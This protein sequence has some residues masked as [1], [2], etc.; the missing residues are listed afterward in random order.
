MKASQLLISCT[1]LAFVA[2]AGQTVSLHAGPSFA[3][4]HGGITVA[5]GGGA[6]PPASS[7][8]SDLDLGDA[9]VSP[10]LQAQI[11]ADGHRFRI[12]GLLVDTDGEG[13]LAD[14]FGDVPAGSQ[15]QTSLDFFALV[16]N[17]S[18]EVLRE[19][20]YRVGIGAQLG[21]YS[22][23]VSATAPGSRESLDTQ[24]LL[25]MPYLEAEAFYGDLTL[26]LSGGAMAGKFGDSDGRYLDLEAYAR[27]LLDDRF[28]VRGGY[29]Y[30]VLDGDGRATDRDFD[31]DLDVRGFYVTAGVR[32]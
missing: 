3:S 23:D 24:G 12:S 27:W 4:V 30:L 22:L 7:V 20:H 14:D 2:C 11:D 26:G 1:S 16:G 8:D 31:A 29:R 15:V 28:D 5:D 6:L 25:P 18:Y 21:F 10:F 9:E 32:F 13:S 19:E 17:Y